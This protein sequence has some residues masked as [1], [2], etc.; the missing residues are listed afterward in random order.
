MFEYDSIADISESALVRTLL[1]THR[2]L[3]LG[4]D[5]FPHAPLVLQDVLL[6]GLPNRPEGDIDILVWNAERPDQPIAIQ[7]KRVKFSISGVRAGEPNKLHELAVGRRQANRLSE[8]GFWKVYLY[9]F[10]VVDTREQN[11]AKNVT[12]EG[13][14]NDVRSKLLGSISSAN[15]DTRVGLINYEL[16]QPLDHAPLSV[17]TGSGHLVRKAQEID[18]PAE[19]TNWVDALKSRF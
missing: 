12:Y 7:A 2:D 10:V 4:I 3:L 19:V 5:G 13:L 9:G 8:I 16:V 11:L 1:D 18:Q 15:L 14:T 17:G 6:Y